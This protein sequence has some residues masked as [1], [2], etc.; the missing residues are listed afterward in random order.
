MVTIRNRHESRLKAQD[1]V[2]R[3]GR[4]AWA[5]LGLLICGG[6]A[7]A[8]SGGNGANGGG[9]NAGDAGIAGDGA[10]ASPLGS[11]CTSSAQCGEGAACAED[12]ACELAHD[13]CPFRCFAPCAPGCAPSEYCEFT[14][15]AENLTGRTQICEPRAAAGELCFLW[16]GAD[17]PNTCIDGYYCDEVHGTP[18]LDGRCVAQ[19]VAGAPCGNRGDYN[20]CPDGYVCNS[21]TIGN[22]TCMRVVGRGGGCLID[23]DCA[24]DLFCKSKGTTGTCQPRVGEGGACDSLSLRP[25]AK[26]LVCKYAAGGQC[27]SWADCM[28]SGMACCADSSGLGTCRTGTLNSCTPPQ[29]TCQAAP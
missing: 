18:T 13:H 27:T 8:C 26:D 11:E 25:C 5:L 7:A 23:A 20:A 15:T 21:H 14:S 10:I 6:A 24:R 22:L 28:Q 29:G 2:A 3:R 19:S 17:A 9:A 12:E 16:S 4:I 1:A